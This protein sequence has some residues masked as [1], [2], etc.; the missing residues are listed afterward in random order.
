ML[1]ESEIETIP[2]SARQPVTAPA[3]QHALP[4][5]NTAKVNA[6]QA[7]AEA[8]LN[9]PAAPPVPLGGSYVPPAAYA[10]DAP[11]VQPPKPGFKVM[12]GSDGWDV[13]F[14]HAI[15]A[16]AAGKTNWGVCL[17][18]SMKIG[19]S[20]QAGDWYSFFVGADK[21]EE[22]ERLEL[23]KAALA[24][25]SPIRVSL[26]ET[27]SKDG[28]RVWKNLVDCC[29][30]PAAALN[31]MPNEPEAPPVDETGAGLDENGNPLF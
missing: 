3:P 1:D 25:N 30:I 20:K 17:H 16:P 10:K 27:P 7:Q 26:S 5:S 24:S 8:H 11:A 19:G 2:A 13:R 21:P 15:K 9:K 31:E 22:S 4:A 23:C 29:V 12:A 6:L 14:V 28:T 18:R